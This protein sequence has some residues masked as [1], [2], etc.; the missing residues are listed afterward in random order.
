[1]DES[2]IPYP[3]TMALPDD[4]RLLS[5]LRLLINGRSYSLRRCN[6]IAPRIRFSLLCDTAI[7]WH[8][9]TTHPPLHCVLINLHS[10]RTICDFGKTV[11]LEQHRANGA[12]YRIGSRTHVLKLYYEKDRG[13]TSAFFDIEWDEACV[14]NTGWSPCENHRNSH[15]LSS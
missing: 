14:K 1:M 11:C 5:G 9:D 15:S 6:S 2:L 4:D 7:C 8:P 3:A 10:G 13:I 12:V